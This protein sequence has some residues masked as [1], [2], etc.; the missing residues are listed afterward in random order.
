MVRKVKGIT[1]SDI[2]KMAKPVHP[3]DKLPCGVVSAS[4]FVQRQ[5]AHELHCA[6]GTVTTLANDIFFGRIECKNC[7]ALREMREP[8]GQQCVMECPHCAV[9]AS[10]SGGNEGIANEH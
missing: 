1:M 8:I 2:Q 10:V 9:P 7:F 5:N 4:H 6:C 3:A